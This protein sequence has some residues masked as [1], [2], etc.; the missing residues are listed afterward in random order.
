MFDPWIRPAHDL[1]ATVS[2]SKRHSHPPMI[3]RSIHEKQSG[4]TLVEL[5]V[6]IFIL[7]VLAAFSLPRFMVTDQTTPHFPLA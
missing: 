3:A 7:G 2:P 1:D 4:F 6:T 5:V